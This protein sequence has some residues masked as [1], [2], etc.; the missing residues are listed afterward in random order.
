MNKK[1]LALAMGAV[2]AMP[3]SA[4]AAPTLYGKMNVTLDQIEIDTGTPATSTDQW[5]LNSNASRLGVKG[6]V[7]ISEDLKGIY[8]AE[9]QIDVDNGA[10][11]ST[12]VV[13][14]VN[15]STTP[16]TVT[17]GS[18][19]QPFS[20]RN[21]YAGLKG[22]WGTFMAGKFDTP[23]KNAQGSVDQFNDLRGDI[24]GIMPGETRADNVIQYSSPKLGEMATV[25]V[26][27]MPAEGSDV[28]GDGKNDDGLADSISA[29]V[30]L[31]SGGLY[32]ALALDSNMTGSGSV[33][34]FS[35]ADIMRLVAAYKM[36][37]FEVGAIFQTAEDLATGSKKED[38]AMLVSAAFKSGEWKFKAQFG[39]GEGDASSKEKTL[40]AVGADYKLGKNSM[41]FGYYSAVET[42]NPA[43]AVDGEVTTLALGMEHK[44]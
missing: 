30:V 18:V 14:A 34:S 39:T 17:T 38:S 3:V 12:T 31:E 11:A 10:A 2:V 16:P 37:A 29:S 26:A 35:R 33:D 4:V 9:Y 6:D 8:Q 44:F 1:L 43:P 27:L 21:I 5:E 23:L 40:M 32:A 28:D 42:D 7:E 19:S 25:N 13:T 15:T 41:L 22:G 24:A 20:Q 36:D